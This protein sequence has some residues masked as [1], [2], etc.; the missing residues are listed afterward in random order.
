MRIAFIGASGTGKTTLA[1]ALADHMALPMNPF[2]VRDA[3]ARMGLESPYDADLRGLRTELQKTVLSSKVQWEK[4]TPH[5][6][7]DRSTLDI[8]AYTYAH[9]IKLALDPDFRKVVFEHMEIYDHVFFCQ[10][11]RFYNPGSDPQRLADITYAR[12]IE[13]LLEDLETLLERRLRSR[14][15]WLT[16][17][18]S[19]TTISSIENALGGAAYGFGERLPK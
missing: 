4:E 1:K 7:T 14:W 8:L 19:F 9:D 6:V 15:Q 2:G 3:A 18:N 13:N 11:F 16:S 10:I 12:M 17:P 5:F